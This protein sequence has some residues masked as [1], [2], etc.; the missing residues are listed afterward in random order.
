[1]DKSYFLDYQDEQEI[2]ELLLYRKVSKINDDTLLLDNGVQL[3]ILP[4]AGCCGC[5]SGYCYLDELNEVDNA[6]TNVIFTFEGIGKDNHTNGKLFKIFVLAESKKILLANINGQ[7][8]NGNYALGYS[9][10]VIPKI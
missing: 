3:Q 4:N 6:I 5:G 9:I 7:Y 1:M 8:G 2:K 10:L